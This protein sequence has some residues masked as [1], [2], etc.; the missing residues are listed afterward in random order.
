MKQLTI[1]LLGLI[2]FIFTS[3]GQ[4]KLKAPENAMTKFEEFKRKKKFNAD[5]QL[6]Y[7]G[8]RDQNQQTS[9]AQKIN[10]AAEDFEKLAKK[11]DATE[12]DYQNAIKIGLNRFTGT[13][14]DS[15][16]QDRICYYFEELMDIIG[17]ESSGGHL[18]NF[19]YGFDPK[20]KPQPNH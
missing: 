10:L 11:G 5:Q 1:T 7:P 16:D 9:F 19:R 3:C 17:L 14:I 20:Q 12:K 18:N 8:I 6:S 2:S 15:E 4:E 13:Y